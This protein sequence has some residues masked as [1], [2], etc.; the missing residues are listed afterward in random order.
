MEEVRIGVAAARAE[1]AGP[2][3]TALRLVE[4][5]A[6]AEVR[7]QFRVRDA[8]I[9]AAE[10]VALAADKLVARIEVAVFRD[11]NIFMA[12]AAARQAFGDTRTV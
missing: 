4:H 12:G 7:R 1:E 6:L 11:S 9:N 8:F 5:M 10:F 3:V 2:A